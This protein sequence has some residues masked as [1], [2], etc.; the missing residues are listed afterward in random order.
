MPAVAGARRTEREAR[1]RALHGELQ[2]LIL[3]ACWCRWQRGADAGGVGAAVADDLPQ[4]LREAVDEWGD[5]MAA[6]DVASNGEACAGVLCCR[7]SG[8]VG[9]RAP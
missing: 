7:R 4:M 8:G 2:L 5:V 1:S 3:W 9:A 6:A